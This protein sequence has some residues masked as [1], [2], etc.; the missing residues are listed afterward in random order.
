[1]GYRMHR[2]HMMENIDRMDS[3]DKMDRSY[4]L[5]S[6]TLTYCCSWDKPKILV[7]GLKKLSGLRG[8]EDL[9]ALEDFTWRLHLEA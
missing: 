3:I 7:Q 2:M 4:K 5:L 6:W 1:M 9:E 8:F